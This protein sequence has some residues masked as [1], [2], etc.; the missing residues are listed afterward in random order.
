MGSLLLVR[1]GQTSWSRAHRHTGL[2]DVPLTAY[3]ERQAGALA[4]VL[5]GRPVVAAW[6]SPLRRAQRTAA[7]AGLDARPDPDL[8]EWD[9]GGYEGRTTAEIRSERPGWWLWTDGVPPG[10]TPGEDADEVAIRCSRVLERVTPALRD[11]DVALVG[12]GHTLRVLAAVW[13]GLAG[14]GGGLFTLEPATLCRLGT[15]RDHRV[16]ESWNDAAHLAG[17]RPDD[18]EAP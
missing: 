16:V 13:L 3:G 8:V 5:A 17:L 2:T 12:H 15:Y 7:L 14:S 11:G 1:H 9:N 4:P 10:D 6:A 18:G